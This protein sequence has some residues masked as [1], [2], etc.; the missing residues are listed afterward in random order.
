[1]TR[2]L[3]EAEAEGYGGGLLETCGRRRFTRDL[4]E[5]EAEGYGGA[6]A[7]RHLLAAQSEHRYP[8]PECVG[9]RRVRVVQH[10]GG[11]V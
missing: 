3:R 10:L 6:D 9:R 11:E 5:A 2:D 7:A 4:R 8:R 1:V